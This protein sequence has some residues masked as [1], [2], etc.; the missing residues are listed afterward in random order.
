MNFNVEAKHS[1][2]DRCFNWNMLSPKSSSGAFLDLSHLTKDER[3]KLHKVCEDDMDLMWK[4]SIRIRYV[5]IIKLP[6]TT[7]MS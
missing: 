4:D 3:D 1:W 2:K 5:S 6:V 7:F